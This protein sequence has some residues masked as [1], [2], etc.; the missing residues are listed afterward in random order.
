[1][2]PRDYCCC[3]IP[4]VNAG[5]YTIIVE[6]FF[7]GILAGTLAVAT[8]QSEYQIRRTSSVQGLQSKHCT[9]VGASTPSFAKWIFAIIC[10]VGAAVQIFGFFGVWK[11]RLV[12]I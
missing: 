4:T 11:V 2:K 12:C 1:M 7:L 5:I 6:Q 8:S 3:A 9:V 10:Y